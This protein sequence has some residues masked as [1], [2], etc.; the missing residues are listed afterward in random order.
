MSVEAIAALLVVL[1]ASLSVHEAAHAWTAD[2]LGDP[3]ARML[4]R[5]TLNPLRHIDPI[6]TVLFPLIS[7]VSGLPLLGWAKPVPVNSHNLQAPRRDFAIVAA[8]G[9]A[10]N[11]LMA[12]GAAVALKAMV[13]GGAGPSFAMMVVANAVTMNVLL[14]VFNLLPIPPLDGGNV[15]AGLVPESAARL[16]DMMRP[17]GFLMLYALMYAGIL[18]DVVMPVQ[19]LIRGWLL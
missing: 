5:L 19:R 16:I 17:Y 12:M 14:A 11:L 1:I 18:G 13:A 4:G 9:P 2:R 3:T 6:G 8:A 15:L 7:I 10:S